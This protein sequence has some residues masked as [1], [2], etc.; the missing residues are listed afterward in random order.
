MGAA[1]AIAP[2]GSAFGC[3]LIAHKMLAA[4]SAMS[5]A[6]KNSD[7]VYKI[8]FFHSAAKVC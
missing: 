4:R 7:L 2:V 6:A 5:A 8:R 3:E 1:S